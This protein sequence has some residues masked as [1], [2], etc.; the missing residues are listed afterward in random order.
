MVAF[1]K[2]TVVLMAALGI[3]LSATAALADPFATI[4]LK[5]RVKNSG[6]DWS[7]NP[8]AVRAGDILEYQ[9]WVEMAAVGARNTFISVVGTNTITTV[10]TI[11]RLVSGTD[12]VNS[13]KFHIY[14]TASEQIQ[15]DFASTVTLGNGWDQGTG[16]SGGAVTGRGSTGKNN[17]LNIRP[18]RATNNFVGVGAQSFIA[19]GQTAA[20]S[21]L[22]TGADSLIQASYRNPVVIDSTYPVVLKFNGGTQW[23]VT[24]SLQNDPA[25]RLNGLTVYQPFA[26]AD[27]RQDSLDNM[28]VVNQGSPVTLDAIGTWSSHTTGLYSWDLDSDG[29]FD[30]ADTR[31]PTLPWDALVALYGPLSWYGAHPIAVKVQT[32]DGETRMDGG[33]LNLVP[34]PATIVL[35]ATGSLMAVVIR[36]RR[37]K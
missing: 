25:L 19:A 13:L 18:I 37:R 2:K 1:A 29:L 36:R 14:Q 9:I 32:A 22:G 23:Q 5:G 12:G 4:I 8:I 16:A 17:L 7:A 27:A 15:M 31:N 21:T 34:E 30:D 20:I 10:R 35:L 28:Y 26:T 33:T 11:T 3:V 24:N 6:N